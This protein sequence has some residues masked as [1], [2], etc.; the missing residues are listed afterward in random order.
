M[1]VS[2]PCQVMFSPPMLETLRPSPQESLENEVNIMSLGSRHNSRAKDVSTCVTH[3]STHMRAPAKESAEAPSHR[4]VFGAPWHQLASVAVLVGSEIL[5]LQRSRAA[6]HPSPL[7]P[8][9]PLDQ[10]HDYLDECLYL[11]LEHVP[12]G[13]ITQAE[14]AAKQ[15]AAEVVQIL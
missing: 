9:A 6:K 5:E 4:G 14:N 10:R 3:E 1:D 11:Y 7:A 8:L 2:I 15:S 13:S 12:G